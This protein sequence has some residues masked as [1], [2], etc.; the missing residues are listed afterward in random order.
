MPPLYSP[1]PTPPQPLGHHQLINNFSG[2]VSWKTTGSPEVAA[3]E[4]GERPASTAADGEAGRGIAGG[5]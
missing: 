4:A 2:K 1:H 5:D 3:V